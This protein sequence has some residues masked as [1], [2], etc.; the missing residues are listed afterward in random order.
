MPYGLAEAWRGAH[1]SGAAWIAGRLAILGLV[2][3]A[4]LTG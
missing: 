2:W 3:L 4:M 1:L